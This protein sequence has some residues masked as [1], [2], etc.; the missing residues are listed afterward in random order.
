MVVC[1][2]RRLVVNSKRFRIFLSSLLLVSALTLACAGGANAGS[3]KSGQFVTY[4]E[5][6]WG[7]G[8]AVAPLLAADFGSVYA[9]TNGVLIVGVTGVP[10]Q[11]FMEF[12]S[13]AA[14][15]D[16]LPAA[17]TPGPLT[18]SF[19]NPTVSP[20]GL[21]GGDVATL[22][23]NLAFNHAG[24]LHGT[25]SIPLGDLLLT[26]FNLNLS[27]LNG[28]TVSQFLGIA[29]TCLGGGSCPYGLGNVAQ[30][31]DD[32]NGSFEA[33]T[34]STFADTNLALPVSATPEPSSLLMFGTGLLGLVPF[35]RKLFGR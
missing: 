11:Y 34:V 15:L 8:G 4:S 7:A 31:T 20:S 29:N 10:S 35:G 28:L 32:L 6:D 23:L 33:G 19:L 16:Y 18:T 5:G 12:T 1:P 25:A 3:I 22:A 21:F 14:V 9:G 13:A 26:N 17:G 27:G 2:L 24:Y 30:T